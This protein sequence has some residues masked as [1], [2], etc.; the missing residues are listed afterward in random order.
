[1]RQRL[2]SSQEGTSVDP[3][4]LHEAVGMLGQVKLAA[5]VGVRD[6]VHDARMQDFGAWGAKNAG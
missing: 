6:R 3:H 1:L 2:T 5:R 4:R